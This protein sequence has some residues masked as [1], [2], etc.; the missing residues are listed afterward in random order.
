[1]IFCLQMNKLTDNVKRDTAKHLSDLDAQLCRYFPETDDTNN[2]IRYPFHVLPPVHLPLSE[3][4]SL[5]EIAT[6]GSVKIEFNQKPLP[7]FWIGLRSEY[8]ALANRSVK[9]LMPF[10]TTCLCESGFSALTSMTTKYRHRLC[11]ENYLRLRLC[12]IQRRRVMRILSST[13]FS[14]TCGELFT[15]FN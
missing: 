9:T 7:D 11:V 6:N 2:W 10:D 8:P 3:Q 12:P 4:Q 15:N 14:L 5:I 13:P 1:M